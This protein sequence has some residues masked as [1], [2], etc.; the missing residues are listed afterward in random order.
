VSHRL[1]G[2]I[3]FNLYIIEVGEQVIGA[4]GSFSG[5]RHIIKIETTLRPIFLEPGFERS[6]YMEIL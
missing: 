4:G 5:V 2:F 1:L 3:I 6:A